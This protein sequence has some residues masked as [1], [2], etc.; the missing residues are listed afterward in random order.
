MG[1]R[2]LYLATRHPDYVAA[3]DVF[4]L[5][6][7]GVPEAARLRKHVMRDWELF[8]RVFTVRG[9]AERWS[10]GANYDAKVLPLPAS[11]DLT[12]SCM[13][14][15]AL[16]DGGCLVDMS[17][18][19]DWTMFFNKLCASETVYGVKTKAFNTG[20]PFAQ[21]A[22]DAA[23]VAGSLTPR[24]R[25][26]AD[27]DN[28]AGAKSS[29]DCAGVDRLA[30][31]A[32]PRVAWSRCG[33][34]TAVKSISRGGA[35][36]QEAS[37]RVA[38]LSRLHLPASLTGDQHRV[39][40][41][42]QAERGVFVTGP[43]GAGKTYLVRQIVRFLRDAGAAVA[44]CGS[45][46]M[47]ASMVGGITAHSWAGFVLG[48]AVLDLPL[49]HVL[50]SVIPAAAKGRMRAAM[51]LVIDEIGTMSA[52]FIERL[53]LV[54][55]AVRGISS[56]FG[57]VKVIF[58]G[59]FLQLAPAQGSLAFCCHAWKDVFGD[60]AV[61]LTTS[62]RHVDDPVFMDLLRRMRVGAQTAADL[63]LLAS[64]RS[65]MPP[66]SAVWLT[67]HSSLAAA[68]NQ[69]MLSKLTGPD[70]EYDAVD[71]VM[72]PYI[73][74]AQASELLDDCT[75]F[76][77]NLLLRTGAVVAVHSNVFSQSGVPAGT[78]GVVMRFDA[79]GRQQ[80][81]VVRFF[82]S[83][84]G[85]KSLRVLPTTATV[86]ALDGRSNAASRTQLPLVLSWASTIHSAQ[87]WTLPS[88]AVD[89]Q[90]AFAPGQVLSALS[91]TPRLTG[92]H[93]VSFDSQKIIVDSVAVAFHES[94][95]SC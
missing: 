94:L 80:F 63:S 50:S 34:S 23:N 60:R 39:L 42:L 24:K 22:P 55:R 71:V 40:H 90:D 59:D 82:L 37:S 3:S 65:L 47:A 27:R 53:D 66:S 93:L 74:K 17:V 62:W 6:G 69:T 88:V 11:L 70:M 36:N 16:P 58:A 72:A 45:S 73:S 31:A 84:G 30:S 79:A 86:F 19:S 78:R 38:T 75:D 2:R 64:R 29:S 18:G 10:R 89:L 56:A 43:P 92:I 51:V 9:R 8:V 32:L 68:K 4:L 25:S 12:V 91:R 46:G 5:A 14:W 15:A 54:L 13:L 21:A 48:H 44:V 85:Y 33:N 35:N 49:S 95:V 67:T 28:P 77:R 20:L 61:Q 7:P 83:S 81:P 26:Y 57:G 41:Q 52:E 87:G 1:E 76:K